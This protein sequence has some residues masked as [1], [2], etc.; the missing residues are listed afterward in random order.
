MALSSPLDTSSFTVVFDLDG[1]LVNTAPD[2]IAALNHTLRDAQFRTVPDMAVS[3]LIGS[4]AKAMIKAGLKHQAADVSET[5][6]DAMFDVFLEHYLQNIAVES[7]PY[8][9]CLSALDRLTDAG[10]TLAVCTNKKQNLAEELLKTLDMHARFSAIVGA[11]SVPN[12]KPDPGHIQAAIKRSNGQ[13]DKAIMIGDSL[14]DERAAH[15]AGLPFLHCPFGYGPIDLHPAGH[16]TVLNK[17]D[18]LDVSFIR[19]SLDD[20]AA[21]ASRDVSEE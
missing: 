6:L 14:S 19:R 17:F 8:D 3:E 10:L 4:G 7:R 21:T 13:I 20:Y 11:D 12:R 5:D 18:D 1:T 9:G 15:A 16:R 2:L